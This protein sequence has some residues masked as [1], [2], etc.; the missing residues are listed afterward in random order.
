MTAAEKRAARR[1]RVLQG[2]E[3]RLKLVTGQISALKVGDSVLEHDMDAALNELLDATDGVTAAPAAVE[4]V[5]KEAMATP[6]AQFAPR[7]DPAQRRR[8]AALRR[9]KKEVVVEQLLAA[10]QSVLG[11]PTAPQVAANAAL[12]SKDDTGASM[13]KAI[14]KPVAPAT[15]SRHALALK[16][17]TFTEK[18]IALLLIA[19]ALYLGGCR[20]I[21]CIQVYKTMCI[22]S[23]SNVF[24]HVWVIAV[25][26]DLGT[27]ATDLDVK[28]PILL[29]YQELLVQGQPLAM[30]R[31]RME[32]EQVRR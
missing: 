25:T 7:P 29:S 31:Q 11:S 30:I 23:G 3:S 21:H 20:C 17:L 1:A 22:F 15:F 13:T 4:L 14:A 27:I 28:D 12:T 19:A 10:R 5:A 8:D 6:D 32:R 18:A 2:S 26:K 16:L 9:Q 24:M